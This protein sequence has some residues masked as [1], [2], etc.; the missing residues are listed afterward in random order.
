MGFSNSGAPPPPL[1]QPFLWLQMSETA[2]NEPL[3]IHIKTY[4]GDTVS[5][6]VIRKRKE[7]LD[8]ATFGKLQMEEVRILMAGKFLD[9]D[10]TLSEFGVVQEQ[11]LFAL[12]PQ[13][14]Q[15]GS[16]NGSASSESQ[17]LLM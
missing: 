12:R 15:S 10:K 1:A 8:G 9:E 13:D 5:F 14:V 17:C 3:K 4:R 2:G 16:E 7:V 6:D 11:V